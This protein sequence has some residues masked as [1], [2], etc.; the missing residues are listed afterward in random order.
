M[1]IISDLRQEQERNRVRT[2][3]ANR[4]QRNAAMEDLIVEVP[5]LLKLR[6]PNGTYFALH[7]DDAGVLSTV[8]MGSSL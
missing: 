6:S 1:S 4:R 8:N 3:E 5:R 2:E 7:V